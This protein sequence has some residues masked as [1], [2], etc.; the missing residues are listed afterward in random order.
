MSTEAG[1]L[2][3]PVTRRDMPHPM[4]DQPAQIPHLLLE[5]RR[6][7]VRI[8]F[9][10]EQQRVPAL[11]ADVLMPAVAIGQLLVVVLAEE[12]RQRV[13]HPR[14]R[15]VLAQVLAAAPAPPVVARGLLE[16]VVVDVMPPQR[17]RQSGQPISHTFPS[18]PEC[19]KP[20]PIG[21]LR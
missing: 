19:A 4:A 16:D 1:I 13:P 2:L 11:R 12:T 21:S 15:A 7:G 9:G 14:E 10:V 3:E 20:L 17:A 6:R 18:V 5:R 8:V